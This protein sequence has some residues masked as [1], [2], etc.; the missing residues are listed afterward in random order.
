[1]TSQVADYYGEAARHLE[2][3]P[4]SVIGKKYK[5]WP[6]LLRVKTLYFQALSHVSI[7]TP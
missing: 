2:T 3:D 5:D 7:G 6:K 4:C 1:M